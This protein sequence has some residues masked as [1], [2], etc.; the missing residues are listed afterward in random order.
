MATGP[1][2]PDRPA[3]PAGGAA[4]LAG[5]VALVTGASSGIGAATAL[6]LARARSPWWPGAPTGSRTSRRRWPSRGAAR[7][8]RYPP[9]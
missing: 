8:S 3:D 6:A 2:A 1:G 5:S 7:P 4:P 9:T